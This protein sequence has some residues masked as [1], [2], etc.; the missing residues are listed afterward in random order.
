MKMN[1]PKEETL[2]LYLL[3][4]NP[5]PPPFNGGEPHAYKNKPTRTE[6]S[7]LQRLEAILVCPIVR[8]LA[9]ERGECDLVL[10]LQNGTG[11]Q[12]EDDRPILL[13]RHV[14]LLPLHELTDLLREQP[15][16]LKVYVAIGQSAIK[17]KID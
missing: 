12:V 8:R 5:S 3:L 13:E 1:T 6:S 16:L 14:H 15:Q 7:P 10:R 9:L 2:S 17:F 4:A 11:L